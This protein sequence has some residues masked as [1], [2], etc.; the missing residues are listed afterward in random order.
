MTRTAA[1]G[2]GD[3]GEVVGGAGGCPGYAGFWAESELEV[4]RTASA[5][6]HRN[7][8]LMIMEENGL[9]C[10]AIPIAVAR[11]RQRYGH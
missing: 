3:F 10:R 4:A 9:K 8:R 1:V 5:V 6:R 7:A 11:I 2:V